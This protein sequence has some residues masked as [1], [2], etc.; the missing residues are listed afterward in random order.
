M[1]GLK[2]RST[3][4]NNHNIIFL[5]FLVTF[6]TC[7]LSIDFVDEKNLKL[8][9]TGTGIV[10]VQIVLRNSLDPDQDSRFS[11]SGLRFLA[12]SGFGFN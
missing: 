2:K 8:G 5:E 6:T 4:L 9:S 10:F 1:Q 12:G 11:G 7:Y 3:M